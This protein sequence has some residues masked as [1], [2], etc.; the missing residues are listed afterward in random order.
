MKTK[1]IIS[2]N[3]FAAYCESAKPCDIAFMTDN[4]SH[5]YELPCL[6]IRMCFSGILVFP[7]HS[8]VF[9]KAGEQRGI[10]FSEVCSIEMEESLIGMIVRL[11][12]GYTLIPKMQMVFTLVVR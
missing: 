11:R 9:L 5:G 4:Q 3:E 7:R 6:G 12:C 10:T 1:K 8:M 2:M